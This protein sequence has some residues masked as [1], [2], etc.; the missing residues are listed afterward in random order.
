MIYYCCNELQRHQYIS[1]HFEKKPLSNPIGMMIS[2]LLLLMTPI[3]SLHLWITLVDDRGLPFGQ[4]SMPMQN[5]ITWLS[6]PFISAYIPAV[7]QRSE[8]LVSCPALGRCRSR[9][10][11]EILEIQNEAV[12]LFSERLIVASLLN[13]QLLAAFWACELSNA[14]PVAASFLFPR[15]WKASV[16]QGS[17]CACVCYRLHQVLKVPELQFV[18]FF[19]PFFLK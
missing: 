5:K 3:N 10:S 14:I 4:K 2:L 9:K 8:L 1:I 17:V 13:S 11:L 7:R 19:S 16:I 15:W 12:P 18:W 6:G